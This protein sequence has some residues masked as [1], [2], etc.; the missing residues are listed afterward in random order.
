MKQ[1]DNITWVADDDKCFIE[2]ETQKVCGLYIQLG[3][4]YQTNIDDTI[5]RYTEI[6][7]TDEIKKELGIN[8]ID[9]KQEHSKRTNLR[10]T[11]KNK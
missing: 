2:T 9:K 11:I 10:K 8:Y 1:L 3:K 7:L 5:D 4:I 6:D